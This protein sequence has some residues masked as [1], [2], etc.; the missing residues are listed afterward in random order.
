MAL[1]DVIQQSKNQNV[2]LGFNQWHKAQ[3][4]K[5]MGQDWQTWSPKQT[6]FL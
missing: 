5:P 2:D 3:T 4:G 6:V 1:T